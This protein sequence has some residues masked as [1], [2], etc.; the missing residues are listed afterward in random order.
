MLNVGRCVHKF[1]RQ[2]LPKH[3]YFDS[4]CWKQKKHTP[5]ADVPSF[6]T[7]KSGRNV[8]TVELLGN[9]I[10]RISMYRK[11][12]PGDPGVQKIIPCTLKCAQL[13]WSSV[14]AEGP[15]P[16]SNIYFELTHAPHQASTV[17]VLSFFTFHSGPA[18]ASTLNWERWESWKGVS[19][20]LPSALANDMQSATHHHP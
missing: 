13:Y 12:F 19:L 2:D 20:A 5:K 15:H 6:P 7:S 16:R 11:T 17:Y 3:G 9:T 8:R 14:G 18:A 1:T 4:P 10:A